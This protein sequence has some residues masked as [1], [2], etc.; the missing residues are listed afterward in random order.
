MRVTIKQIYKTISVGLS[1]IIYMSFSKRKATLLRILEI[2]KNILHIK[3]GKNFLRLNKD[4][5]TLEGAN[6]GERVLMVHSPD[7]L[8]EVV[9]VGRSS[10]RVDEFIALYKLM[11]SND[12]DQIGRLSEE[13]D[14][15][16]RELFTAEL[17]Q[18]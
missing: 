4:L 8:G 16:R 12:W 7:D 13:K 5:K 17:P 6:R 18:R 1:Y 10:R 15:L 2:E 9:E 3:Q 14:K 11:M